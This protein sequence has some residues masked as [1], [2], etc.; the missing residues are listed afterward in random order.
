[1]CALMKKCVLT[2][3]SK[4]HNCD[5]CPPPHH[6]PAIVLKTALP[7]KTFTETH[8]VRSEVQIGPLFYFSRFLNALHIRRRNMNAL[9]Y[10]RGYSK[11]KNIK[12]GVIPHVNLAI[13]T[14]AASW[15]AAFFA[16]CWAI[17]PKWI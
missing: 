2:P 11:T 4:F 3:R 6:T 13:L 15:G 8:H 1:M 16:V 12:W 10:I 7:G 9:M 5:E 17:R 14:I